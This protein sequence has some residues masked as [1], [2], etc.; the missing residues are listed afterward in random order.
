MFSCICNQ[1]LSLGGRAALWRH[2]FRCLPPLFRW[3][4][5]IAAAH[6]FLRGAAP[7]MSRGAHRPALGPRGG[8]ERVLSL[9]AGHRL[10]MAWG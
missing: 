10:A 3:A 6:F 2:T 9:S 8:V 1:G 7:V 5:G 4:A